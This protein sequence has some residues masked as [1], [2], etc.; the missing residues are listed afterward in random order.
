MK[1][2]AYFYDGEWAQA[3]PVALSVRDGQLH[4]RSQGSLR[5]YPL[6]SLVFRPAIGQIS[7]QIG[8]PDGGLLEVSDSQAVRAFFQRRRGW[9][10]YLEMRWHFALLAVVFTLLALIST[11]RW[12]LPWMADRASTLVPQAWEQR[13][14]EETLQTLDE[15]WFA[16]S[17]LTAERKQHLYDALTRELALPADCCTLLFRK[18]GVVGANALALPGGTLLITDELVALA[19]NDEEIL[20][21]LAHEVGHIRGRHS[22][23]MLL[24]A[25]G[26]G[27]SMALLT[28]D[29]GT[30]GSMLTSAP[31]ILMQLSYSREFETEADTAALHALREAGIASCHF[32]DILTRLG[33][34][35]SARQSIPDWLMS[36]PDGVL[37]S[38]AFGAGCAVASMPKH[39][40]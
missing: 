27:V 18:G 34:Q 9:I 22:V 16:P 14:G 37:R 38:Q 32:T 11:Y 5:I 12:G 35:A 30:L 25:S 15:H 10:E 6:S 39:S 2:E 13:L 40:E 3:H 21:V 33:A 7:A 28:G 1:L 4:V 36:H 17:A 26:I 19:Q 29:V 8:L 20:A 31:A 23:R 24:R